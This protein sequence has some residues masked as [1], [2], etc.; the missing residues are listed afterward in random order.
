MA[1]LVAQHGEIGYLISEILN[2][3]SVISVIHNGRRVIAIEG[4][5]WDATHE[6]LL[7]NLHNDLWGVVV[8]YEALGATA[9]DVDGTVKAV[10]K[11]VGLI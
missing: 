1:K 6:N 7:Q 9:D 4:K 3:N 5:T 8:K 10:L 11:E 2:G